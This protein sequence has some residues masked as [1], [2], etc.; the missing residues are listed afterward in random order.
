ML[1]TDF[2]STCIQFRISFYSYLMKA[3]LFRFRF[4]K[5]DRFSFYKTKRYYFRFYF[6][7]R[8]ENRSGIKH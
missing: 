2:F 3:F 6:R 7:F 4:L 8:N 5:T 1:N